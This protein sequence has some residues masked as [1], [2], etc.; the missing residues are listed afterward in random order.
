[1]RFCCIFSN[2]ICQYWLK[3]LADVQK[4]NNAMVGNEQRLD[5]TNLC[6][7]ECTVRRDSSN[8]PILV[9][10]EANL[11]PCK[12]CFAHLLS[13]R[14]VGVTYLRLMQKSWS[15]LMGFKSPSVH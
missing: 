9:Y 15:S 3:H 13:L 8:L 1:M 5:C 7:L 6:T 10:R 11:D 4:E 2:T 12:K 14:G